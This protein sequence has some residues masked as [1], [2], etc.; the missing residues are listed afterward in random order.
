MTWAPHRS[1]HLFRLLCGNKHKDNVVLLTTMWDKARSLEEA[2][3]REAV[4]KQR[5][6]RVTVQQTATVDRFYMNDR[7]SLW[8]IVNGMVQR[9]QPGPVLSLQERM[10]ENKALVRNLEGH[11]DEHKE[12]LISLQEQFNLGKAEAKAEMET[13][14]EEL[15]GLRTLIEGVRNSGE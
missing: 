5:F 8:Q 1:L 12:M 2:G 14:R 13:L 4:L 15:A 10:E 7:E 9:Y 3:K 11:L 6:G